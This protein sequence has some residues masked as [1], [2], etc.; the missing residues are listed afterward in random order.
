MKKFVY[1]GF[2][3]RAVAFSIDHI[4]LIVF[5]TI[6]NFALRN[7]VPFM[8]FS[9]DASEWSFSFLIP[10]FGTSAIFNMIYFTFFH[11]AGGQTPGKM[12]LGLKVIKTSG[13]PVTPGVAFL[14]WAGYLISRIVLMLGFLWVAFDP[15]K[16]G[17]HDKI[18]GTYVIRTGAGTDEWISYSKYDA[19]GESLFAEHPFNADAKNKE[20]KSGA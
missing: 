1:G 15:K 17:W 7:A 10:Y 19:A 4:I 14:R 3:R 12:L 2:W 18:A 13:E 16:Q 9:S 20:I 5:I 6:L 8:D 11:S